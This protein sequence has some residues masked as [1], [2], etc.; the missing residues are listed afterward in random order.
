MISTPKAC[1]F[2]LDGTLVDS[3]ADIADATNTALAAHGFPTHSYDTYRQIV[4]YGIK[5]L[6]AH[7]L[8]EGLTMEQIHK[9]LPDMRKHY[10]EGWMKKTAPY[11]GV[12]ALLSALQK[13]GIPLG[14]VSNKPHSSALKVTAH[15][16]PD[17]AFADIRGQLPE[18]PA[19]PDPAAALGMAQNLGI[20]PETVFFIGDTRTDMETAVN[21]GMIG[22]GVTWGFR[23]ERELLDYG[24]RIIIHSPEELLNYCG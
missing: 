21:A 11:P 6:I 15:Y 17:T 8:P 7:A 9:I 23:D 13:R 3:L 20:A 22:V 4:G 24:A 12:P 18:G 1:F 2:D 14:I 10:A 5:A 16:F 19:K